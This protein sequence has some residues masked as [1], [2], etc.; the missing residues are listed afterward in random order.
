MYLIPPEANAVG[1]PLSMKTEA[2]EVL[3]ELWAEKA[4]PFELSVGRLTKGAD[5]YTIHF[6]D[7][8]IRTVCVP[9]TGHSFKDLVRIAVLARV[10][11]LGAR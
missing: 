9:L 3:N 8:R 6:Y 2:Q 11:K 5:G 4:I 10:A 7:S 1:E